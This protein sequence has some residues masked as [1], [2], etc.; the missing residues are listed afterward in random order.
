M[1]NSET[2]YQ[3]LDRSLLIEQNMSNLFKLI[4]DIRKLQTKTL[5]NKSTSLSFKTKTDILYD[6][7]NI[8]QFEYKLFVKFSEIRNQFV[9]NIE[10][11]TFVELPN[12]IQKFLNKEF[13]CQTKQ[14]ENLRLTCSYDELQAR[15]ISK[16]E[17]LKEEYER[18]KMNNYDRYIAFQQKERIDELLEST[19]SH[20]MYSKEQND[21]GFID[22]PETKSDVEIFIEMFKTTFYSEEVNITFDLPEEELENEIHKRKESIFD[23][24]KSKRDG[25]R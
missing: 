11:R 15:V 1:N 24:F 6:L 2:R 5:D 22:S 19:K 12:E 14:E 9:H 8:N 21:Y 4:F 3:I 17:M 23:S 20:F 7:N 25:N 13:P 18:G 10:V 16:I